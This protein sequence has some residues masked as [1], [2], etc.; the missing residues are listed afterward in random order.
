MHNTWSEQI[1]NWMNERNFTLVN[2][3][4]LASNMLL[5]YFKSNLLHHVSLFGNHGNNKDKVHRLKIKQIDERWCRSRHFGYKGTISTRVILRD[6]TQ[7]VFIT[8]HFIAEERFNQ[9]RIKQYHQSLNCTFPEDEIL[10][11]K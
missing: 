5:I 11:Q 9:E 1:S 6:D 10:I 4:C 8:S 7:L 3:L 2:K